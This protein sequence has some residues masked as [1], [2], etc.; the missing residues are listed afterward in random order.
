MFVNDPW[1]LLKPE[2]DGQ[3]VGECGYCR[4]PKLLSYGLTVILTVALAA[5]VRAAQ[6]Y[7]GMLSP[8][9]SRFYKLPTFDTTWA[10]TLCVLFFCGYAVRPRS[11]TAVC[12]V[13]GTIVGISTGSSY[14]HLHLQV[15]TA[16]LVIDF[17]PRLFQSNEK[18]P[19]FT[20]FADLYV[21]SV[22]LFHLGE[23]IWSLFKLSVWPISRAFRSHFL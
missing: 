9:K 22:C 5:S 11:L 20:P 16:P 6:C 1:N 17:F 8:S 2:G 3:G 23:V 19:V 21:I 7:E 18:Y 10:L 13:V 15:N 12:A 4:H 14:C